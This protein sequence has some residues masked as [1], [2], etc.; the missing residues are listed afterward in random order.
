[1]NH[2]SENTAFRGH[3]TVGEITC[4]TPPHVVKHQGYQIV[5][6]PYLKELTTSVDGE[7]PESSRGPEITY[8]KSE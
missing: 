5:K 6:R 4:Q 3:C 7:S 1:M 2:K 8:I